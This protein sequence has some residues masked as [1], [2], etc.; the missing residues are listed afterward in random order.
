M[1][2]TS[3]TVQSSVQDAKKRLRDFLKALDTVPTDILEGE[4]PR[5]Y[6]EI[7]SEV[8]Y[9]TG[10]LERSVRVSVSRDSRRPGLHASAS[11]H[12]S[13]GY[14]YAGVQHENTKFYHPVKGKAHFISD[15]FER[16]T[17]RIIRKIRRRLKLSRR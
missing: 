5:L 13:Q 17:H 16:A 7:L 14:D 8:P 2:R 12:S 1:S 3:A 6:G 15:P 11:A 9:K 4:A 10:K